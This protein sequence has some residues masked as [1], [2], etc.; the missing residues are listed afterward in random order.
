MENK[1]QN[2]DVTKIFI[3]VAIVIGAIL[4][5]GTLLY[6]RGTDNLKAQ[7]GDSINVSVDDDPYIGDKK[8]KVTIVEFSDFQ[9]PFCRSFYNESF[10][11]IKRD[12]IDT[13]KSVKFVYRDFPL[14]FHPM[15]VPSAQ[16]ANCAN[17]QGKFWEASDAIFENQDKQGQG[18]ITYTENE[19]MAWLSA[20]P[21]L[22]TS[23]VKTCMDAKTYDA[24]IQND[25][26]DGAS[27]GVTGTPTI[28]ING[29][30]IVGAQPYA[31]F[32]AAIDAALAK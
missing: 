4:I 6:T 3:P 2:F 23:K 8:A 11:Q 1:T 15:A 27:Y 12:Y 5:S 13:G 17:E 29:S 9:C 22:D 28:F 26:A 24:E 20:V 31:V 25:S 7:A 21:G 19:L 14:S 30:P 10:L 32:K 16:A 18:T